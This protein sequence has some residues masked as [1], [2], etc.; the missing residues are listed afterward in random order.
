MKQVL[1]FTLGMLLLCVIGLVAGHGVFEHHGVNNGQA[2]LAN[3]TGSVGPRGSSSVNDKNY[4][5]IRFSF[6]SFDLVNGLTRSDFDQ[7]PSHVN[8]GFYLLIGGLFLVNLLN[9]PKG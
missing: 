5:R 3:E 7:I 4:K 6:M 9:K 1:I 2:A 8:A